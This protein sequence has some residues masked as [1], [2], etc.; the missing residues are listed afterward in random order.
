MTARLSKDQRN[1]VIGVLKAG[2]TVND[3][4]HHFGCSRQTIHNL[5]NPY[6]ITGSVRA[7]TRP[8]RAC[9]TTLRPY[10]VNTLTR[11]PNCFY[12]QQLLLGVYGVHAQ[13]VINH[14]MQNNGPDIFQHDNVRLQTTHITTHLNG[15]NNVNVLPWPALSPVMNHIEHVWDE[16][17]RRARSN[18]QMNTINDPK[19]RF[20]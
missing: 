11:P 17:G 13:M 7:R 10:H 9:V 3:T 18:H 16:L 5:V 12:Q 4:A 8:S 14:I 20:S 1:Q 15:Q 19:K 2:S 6:S